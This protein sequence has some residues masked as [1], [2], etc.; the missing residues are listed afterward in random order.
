MALTKVVDIIRR[1]ERM[2]NDEGGVRWTRLELQDWLNDGYREIVI[3]RPDANSQ[4]ATVSL[5]LGTRQKLADAGSINLPNALRVLDVVR[6]MAVASNKRVI[7][8]IERRILDEQ[9]P[10]WHAE[11]ASLNILHWMFDIKTPKEFLVYPPAASGTQVEIVYSS[12]PAQHALTAEQLDPVDVGNIDTIN[13]DDI[14]V[15]SLIDYMFYR[16]YSK[17]ADYA[18]NGARAV[19][20]LNAFKAALGLKT[21]ADVAVAPK[22]Q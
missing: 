8:H 9:S 12:I 4:S 5:A 3:V 17:D 19:G 21:Q 15:N 18:A 2:L 13:I 14:Y 11:T 6:N 22:K 16:A 20:A 7:R 1:I 10:T